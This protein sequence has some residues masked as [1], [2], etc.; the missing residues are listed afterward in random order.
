M[1]KRCKGCDTDFS[2]TRG[3]KIFCSNDCLKKFRRNL[4]S[5]PYDHKPHKKTPVVYT[6]HVGVIIPGTS[7]VLSRLGK[8]L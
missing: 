1:I 7:A 3:N 4:Y 6:E 8:V 2:S 5:I